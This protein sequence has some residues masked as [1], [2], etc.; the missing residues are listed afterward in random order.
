MTEAPA[1]EVVLN[2]EGVVLPV[3]ASVAEAAARA[4]AHV[5][6]D[7]ST[8]GEPQ[9]V[10]VAVDDV[11]VPRSAWATTPLPAGARVEVVHLVAG[12]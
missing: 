3:G 9:G 5:R 2:G 8:G 10:A 12:G 1:T 4:L 7:D 6:G 11:V